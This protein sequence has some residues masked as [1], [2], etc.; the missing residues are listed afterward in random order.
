MEE[1]KGAIDKD[2]TIEYYKNMNSA[3]RKIVEASFLTAAETEGSADRVEEIKK[4]WYCL[5]QGL[6]GVGREN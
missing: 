5:L 6:T 4:N 2:E 1:T 3:D